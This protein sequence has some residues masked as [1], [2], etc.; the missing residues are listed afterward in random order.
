MKNLKKI[1]AGLILAGISLMILGCGNNVT[2]PQTYKVTYS[3]G[4]GVEGTAPSDSNLYLTGQTVTLAVAVERIGYTFTAWNDGKADYTAGSSYTMGA[5]NVTFTAQWK[6]NEVKKETVTNTT[7]TY[8]VT[9]SLGEGVEGTAPTDDK[10]YKSGEKVTLAAAQTRTGYSFSK[11]NDGKNDYDAGAEYTMGSANVTFTAKWTAWGQVEAPTFSVAAGAVDAGTTVTITCSTSGSSI[12][13]TTDG[14]TPTS[15]STAYSTP[16]T[17]NAAMTL[18][19]I[20]VKS[21]MTDSAVASVAYSIWDSTGF[22]KINAGSFQ[23]GS[24]KGYDFNK[25]VHNVT[26]SKTY[27]MSDHEVTQAEYQAVMGSNPSYFNGTSGKE[28]ATGE[29]QDN[30]PVENVSWYMAIVYCNKKSITDGLKPC[31][32]INGKT[33]PADWGD[34]PTSSD[35][36]WDAVTC[37]FSKNG[38]RLPTEAEWEYAAR[39]GDTAVDELTWSGTNNF[40]SLNTYAW[41]AIYSL[42]KTHE[43]KKAT[44]GANAWNLYDM[45]GNVCEWCWDRY[46]AYTAGDVTDPT[47]DTSG[48]PVFRGGAWNSESKFCAVSCRLR[49]TPYKQFDHL[50][51]RLCRS[52]Q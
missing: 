10:K 37:E 5:A 19:A 2:L 48:D 47:G 7:T 35:T 15:S 11:W 50:G 30:R 42:E 17:I 41:Y 14:S 16:V 44:N 49:Y 20:A 4:E 31:Y 1:L 27:Y 43:V 12:Y 24:N 38:Y 34:I 22:V 52:A 51:F 33:N 9:Y 46:S 26:I 40:S 18:K 25:P 32:K 29:I 8:T 21:G 28:A 13:Y 3:L 6:K 23:M 45:S 39:A 36:R